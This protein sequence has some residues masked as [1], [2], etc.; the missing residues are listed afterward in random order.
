MRN[1]TR[2]FLV[3]FFVATFWLLLQ[4]VNSQ[5]CP[6]GAPPAFPSAEGFGACTKGGRGG[7]VIEVTNLND[8]GP[9]SLRAALMATGPRLVVF[10]VSGT[11]NLSSDIVMSASQSYL[12]VAGQSSPGG[13]QTKG[14]YAIWMRDGAHDIIIRHMRVRPGGPAITSDGGTAIGVYAPS[15][16]VYNVIIDHSSMEWANDSLAQVYQRYAHDITFQWNIIAEGTQ[17][18]MSHGTGVHI[19]LGANITTTFHH[20]LIA[21]EIDRSPLVQQ[22]AAADWRN[23]VVYNWK[24]TGGASWGSW[25]LNNSAFGNNINNHYIAGPNSGRP[26][27]WLENGGPTRL[28]NSSADRGGTKIYTSGNW[29][30]DCPSGCSDDWSNNW[31]DADYYR[32]YGQIQTASASRYRASTP[33]SVPT[34]TTDP[35]SILKD[36]VLASVGAYKPTRDSVDSRIIND[37]RNLTGNQNNIGNGGPWPDLASGAPVAPSDSD[38]DGMPDNWEIAHGLNPKDPSDGAKIS[39]NGYTNLE[40]YLNELAGDSIPGIAPVQAPTNLTVRE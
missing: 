7:A 40:N 34:V 19:G 37:V 31:Y 22:S 18:A 16:P 27:L 10:R 8:S 2:T 26:F 4:P 28:N 29:G 14:P 13:I 9:G 17:G 25:D 24:N 20:N 11:I 36:K 15:A 32:M 33:Y 38:H 1:L 6:G 39:S 21:H 5:T 23:N 12:T 3:G 35:T 30:P